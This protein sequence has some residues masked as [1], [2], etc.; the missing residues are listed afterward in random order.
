MDT[1]QQHSITYTGTTYSNMLNSV[2]WG[3]LDSQGANSR[4]E[5]F[6]FGWES[7]YSADP[8]E[9]NAFWVEYD[10]TSYDYHG[11]SDVPGGSGSDGRLHTYMVV[12]GENSQLALYFDFNPIAS[13]TKAESARIGESSGGLSAETLEAATFAG[14]YQHRIQLLDGNYTWRRPWVAEVSTRELY[15][16]DAPRNAPATG[17]PNTPPRCLTAS[18]VAKAGTNPP[19]VDYFEVS[20]PSSATLQARAS[21]V[22]VTGASE[23]YNGV[24]QRALAECMNADASRCVTDVPGLAECIG[25][26]KACNMNVQ[27]SRPERG[28]KPRGVSERQALD[29]ARKALTLSSRSSETAKVRTIS[30]QKPASAMAGSSQTLPQRDVIVVEGRE[31]VRSLLGRQ[32]EG[33]D[34]YRL[35]FDPVNGSLLHACLGACPALQ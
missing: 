8:R 18:T 32:T 25:A 15:P 2:K 19:S 28:T 13:T 21:A 17:G 26:H 22:P 7:R 6:E 34:G 3:T 4:S 30:A 14:P 33:Y 23:F 1:W 29:L 9:E 24:D 27:R 20:K 5:G 10:G 31:K 16:C 12:P 11:L 35:A